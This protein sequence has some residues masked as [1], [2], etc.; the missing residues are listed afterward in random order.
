[1]LK[2]SYRAV[3][4]NR[5]SSPS[6][7]L[8]VFY[9]HQDDLDLALLAPPGVGNR[10]PRSLA[11]DICHYRESS[12]RCKFRNASSSV[13]LV[14]LL[15][16]GIDLP[17]LP[18]AEAGFKSIEDISRA[19]VTELDFANA[20]RVDT[21]GHSLPV[22]QRCSSKFFSWLTTTQCT[23][24]RTSTMPLFRTP[25]AGRLLLGTWAH[26]YNS[27]PTTAFRT[28]SYPF[29]HRVVMCFLETKLCLLDLRDY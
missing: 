27:W 2:W 10:M 25:V 5:E 17:S 9:S 24:F 29:R 1:M 15:S 20:T 3:F 23:Q 13:R 6:T 21:H 8:I 22:A 14:D 18:F 12:S 28:Q 26:I 7:L 19:N 4:M 16:D 11:K